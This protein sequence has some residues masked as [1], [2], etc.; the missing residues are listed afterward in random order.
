MISD[1]FISL[2]DRVHKHDFKQTPCIRVFD[3]ILTR[4]SML[5]W[6]F[7]PDV[8]K[9]GNGERERA[10]GTGKSKIGTNREWKIKFLIFLGS[11][12]DFVPIFP[13]PRARFPLPIPRCP[14]LVLVTPLF[15][16]A[17]IP[18]ARRIP[19]KRGLQQQGRQDGKQT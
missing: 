7:F 6:L 2:R 15:S 10:R 19:G 5:A 9:T 1:L 8:T 17:F 14:F 4:C 12:L 16:L 18:P 11:K 13:V 3:A